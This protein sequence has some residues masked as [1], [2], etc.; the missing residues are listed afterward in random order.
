MASS[1]AIARTYRQDTGKSIRGAKEV[2]EAPDSGEIIA[3]ALAT[4]GCAL[5]ASAATIGPVP[6]RIGGAAVRSGEE[7][8]GPIR[9]EMARRLPEESIPTL[10]A[11]QLGSAAQVAGAATLAR[12]RAGA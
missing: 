2:F 6:I 3:E 4:L 12:R 10:S 7:L 9:A 5:A 8:F 11:A 1:A